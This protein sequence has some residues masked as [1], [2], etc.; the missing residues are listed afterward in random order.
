LPSRLFL[1][2]NEALYASLRP[3]LFRASAQATHD[4]MISLLR[5]LD[6]QSWAQAA[7]A[8]MQ[9]LAFDA[10]P[11]TVGGVT[12]PYPLILAAGFVKGDGF[13][14]ESA[15]LAAVASDRNIIPGWRSMPALVGPVEFGSFT[16]W[17]RLGNPGTV[18]WRDPATRSTQNRVGLKNPG[19]R[20]AAAFL[21]QHRDHLPQV[22]GI[23]IAVSPGVTDPAQE[24]Q[25]ALEAFR[26]FL[27]EAIVPSWFTL[28]ISCPNT[29]DDPSGHQTESRARDLC[30]AV[31]KLLPVPLW[32]KISP[33][34]AAEQYAILMRVFCETGVRAVIASNT[35]ARPSPEDAALSAGVGGG[36]LHD[37][38]L[39]ATIRLA[40]TGRQLDIIACG[41][42]MDGTS[43]RDFAGVRAA[44]YWSALVY[45][46]PLAAALILNE[47]AYV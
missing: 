1:R 46:G 19:A 8:R 41:G 10:Q 26:F 40:Q 45:R 33:D 3:L 32:V 6:R 4:K 18:I 36:L 25:E 20:A 14:D 22:Y 7:L 11:V 5:W 31:V 24:Q 9:K 35:L 30:A 34:L 44:Q 28:N 17:P 29:E 47:V 12:L 43:Y 2:L 13:G 23:N 27:Q 42:V 16:R 38:A 21:A 37:H 39:A 15:A